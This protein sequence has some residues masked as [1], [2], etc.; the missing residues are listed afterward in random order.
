M[1]YIYI[2]CTF[3]SVLLTLELTNANHEN[4]LNA[5]DHAFLITMLCLFNFTST[6]YLLLWFHIKAQPAISPSV[7]GSKNELLLLIFLQSFFVQIATNNI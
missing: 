4:L 3:S 6:I 1:M 5:H 7:N 2:V